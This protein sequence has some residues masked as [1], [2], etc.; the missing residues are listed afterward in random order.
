VILVTLAPAVLWTL[1]AVFGVL[2]IA[3]LAVAWLARRKPGGHG[4]L[5]LRV[6][7]WWLMVSLFSLALVFSRSAALVLFGLI[8]FLAL[9][10]YLSLIPT[11]RADRRVLFWAYLAIPVQFLWVFMEWYGMFIIFVPVYMFLGLAFRMVVGG[12]TQDAALGPDDH[13]VQ[14]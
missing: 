10:E 13:A 6:K 7:S 8:S 11:R 2:V 4:E 12:V 14:P 5:V 3:S 9:K 1:A